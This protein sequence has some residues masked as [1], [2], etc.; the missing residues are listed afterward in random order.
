MFDHLKSV[1]IF[2]LITSLES[3]HICHLQSF[4]V[5]YSS[6]SLTRFWH[7]IHDDLFKT[8][9]FSILLKLSEPDLIVAE[10]VWS[11]VMFSS[12]LNTDREM[13]Q[14]HILLWARIINFFRQLSVTRDCNNP[15]KHLKKVTFT[16]FHL[17]PSQQIKCNTKSI[18]ILVS[19]FLYKAINNSE[20]FLVWNENII[21][22]KISVKDFKCFFS[23]LHNITL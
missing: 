17:S 23:H 9:H 6:K 5:R 16:W 14:H 10:V 1:K 11:L 12:R 20:K 22:C 18:E 7:K 13:Q 8:K 4:L 2:G 15:L 3:S 19:V 21:L